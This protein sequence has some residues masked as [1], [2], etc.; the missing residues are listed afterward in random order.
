MTAEPAG[1]EQIDHLRELYEHER[2]RVTQLE[3]SCHQLERGTEDLQRTFAELRAWLGHMNELHQ[4]STTIGALLDPQEVLTRTLQGL[5]GLVVHEFACIYMLDGG[6]ASREVIRG[7]IHLAPPPTVRVGEGALGQVLAGIER[8]IHDLEG[9]AL[10]VALRASG[11]TIGALY[12]VRGKGDPVDEPERKLVEMVAMEAGAAIQ[13][14]RLHE[15]TRRLATTDSLTGL[16]NFRYFQDALRMEI[17]RARRLGYAIGLLM[18]DIDDFKVINDTGGI[19]PETTFSGSWPTSSAKPFARPTSWSA[20]A[21]RSSRSSCRDCR[22]ALSERSTRSC[23][24]RWLP[25]AYRIPGMVWA[26]TSRSA[27]AGHPAPGVT[28]TPRRSSAGPMKRSTRRSA[29]ARTGFAF[30]PCLHRARR[31]ERSL[32]LKYIVLPADGDPEMRRL[33]SIAHRSGY[34][35]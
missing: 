1:S 5:H 10:I 13:K 28:W 3:A 32:I 33:D 19:P 9:Q 15:Q 11:A 21:V 16:Y 4:F 30:G 35:H 8:V 6:I 18:I 23:A 17:A 34:S 25:P 31:R 24:G 26:G 12:L 20:T 29:R 22:L 7:P 27:S 14:A 2:A